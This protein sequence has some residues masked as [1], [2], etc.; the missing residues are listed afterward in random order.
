MGL[1][2]RHVNVHQDGVE[3][4][5]LRM[6]SGFDAVAGHRDAVPQLLQQPHRQRLIDRVV[7]GQQQVQ[8]A[9]GFAQGVSSDQG[10]GLRERIAECPVPS[11]QCPVPSAV[12]MVPNE[13]DS[14][15]GFIR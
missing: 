6:R 5:L 1:L 2:L 10:S 12:M 8:R 14:E 13:S 7:L 3:D 4:A 9:A 15:T 11:A